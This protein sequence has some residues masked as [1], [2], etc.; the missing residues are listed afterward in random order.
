MSLR[1]R[2]YKTSAQTRL[3]E[4]VAAYVQHLM[5]LQASGCAE[6]T[7]DGS[8]IPP[9]NA[10]YSSHDFFCAAHA[11]PISVKKYTARL[12][13]YMHCSPEVFVF[14]V[15]YL[16][17]LVLNGFPV[18]IRSI[19]RLLLTAVLV[20]LKYRDDIYYHTSFYAEVG[21]VTPKDLCIMEMRFLFDLI[22]FEGEVSLA[23]YHTVIRDITRVAEGHMIVKSISTESETCSQCGTSASTSTTST[24]DD[25]GCL[26]E[27]SDTCAHAWTRE[28]EVFWGP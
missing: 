10:Q 27:T 12:V 22:R 18:H 1:V 8:V 17:R 4:I 2:P 6:A 14:A 28:C 5:D 15:A 13:T 16:R 7:L 25:L 9:P 11:P 23:D 20:A 19:H 24:P 21:G 3:A 26:H